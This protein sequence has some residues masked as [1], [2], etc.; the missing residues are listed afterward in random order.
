MPIDIRV[1]EWLATLTEKQREKWETRCARVNA[2][3]AATLASLSWPKSIA[4][5]TTTASATG[6]R[7][8]RTLRAQPDARVG[9]PPR[10]CRPEA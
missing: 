8:T 9:H 10:L 1:H 6:P 4:W 3:K 7:A 2:P 5:S